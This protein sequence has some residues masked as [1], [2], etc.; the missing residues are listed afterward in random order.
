M[1]DMSI[2]T[3]V[4]PAAIAKSPTIGGLVAAVA[5]A[6]TRFARI[7]RRHE[8]TVVSRR[9]G[10]TYS[11]SYA[12]L[13]DVLEAVGS[14]LA[15]QGV[16]I[17]QFPE[18][19]PGF[20]GATT[21]LA[22]GE[23]WI[24]ASM[25][26]PESPDGGPQAVGS[27]ITYAR[28]Y[29]LMSLLALAAGDEDDDAATAQRIALAAPQATVAIDPPPPL[30]AAPPQPPEAPEAPASDDETLIVTRVLEKPTT[31]PGLTRYEIYL[32]DGR[33]VAT[34][35]TPLADRARQ[36]RDERTPVTVEV[37]E[38]KYGLNLDD[39]QAAPSDDEIPF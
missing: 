20:I 18:R 4:P 19:R 31:K 35:K 28:R 13:E 33:K 34:L 10:S 7:A 3:D 16:A 9:T 24:A 17:F 36:F 5:Q 1:S 21:L 12:N 14:A 6:R 27:A 23:E 38:T 29:G 11:Y 39:I 8:A 2:A 32:S 30:P 15:E 25:L 26:V 37:R 22:K